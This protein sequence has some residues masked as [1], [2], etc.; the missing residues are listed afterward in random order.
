MGATC[1]LLAHDG[2]PA[3]RQVPP[4]AVQALLVK[5]VAPIYPPLARQARIQGVVVLDIIINKTGHVSDVK[6]VS[7][8]PMLAPAAIAAVKQWK[9]RP[10]EENDQPLEI[11]T[12]IQVNFTFADGP[13]VGSA[14]GDIFGSTPGMHSLGFVRMCEEVRVGSTSQRLRVSQGV[15][16]NMAISPQSPTYPE[17]A[18]TQNVEGAV[19]LAVE[20]GKDGAVC[21]VA[22]IRGN[23]LLA[24]AAIAAVREWKFRPYILN[25]FPA[26]VETEVQVN[27]TLKPQS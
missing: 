15:M 20:I 3:P 22:L 4:D 8:H 12:T 7:G 10:F 16:Q 13:P 9:Y 14:V 24:P 18:R 5:R 1:L 6:L 11:Q 27:F 19:L 25:S 26:E 17:E 23:R 2:P 21:D